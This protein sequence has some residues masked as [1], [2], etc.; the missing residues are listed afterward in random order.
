M[1]FLFLGLVPFSLHIHLSTRKKG[2]TGLELMFKSIKEAIRFRTFLADNGLHDSF[3]E[4][5]GHFIYSFQDLLTKK[6]H[7]LSAIV[8][9]IRSIKR[10]E[11]LNQVLIRKYRFENEDE[12]NEIMEIVTDMFN[13]ERE[14]LTSLVGVIAEKEIIGESVIDLLNF[15]GAV[16]FDS[17]LR[18]RLKNYFE[19][20]SGYLE[21]AIDE[22]KMEQDYQV[23]IQ[24]LR[25]YL[26][27]RN[28]KQNIVHLLLERPIHFFD[29]A[30]REMPDE[31][32]LD[33]LDPRL[34]SNHP[35]YVD[36]AVIAPLLSMAPKKI[37]LYT[38][39]EDQPLVRTLANIFEERLTIFPCH[40]LYSLSEAYSERS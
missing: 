19:R 26:H 28:T 33:I 13:G 32:I 34:L 10:N 5:R 22:Y 18:F 11:W 29:E 37:F 21:V 36:S 1:F 25:D 12:R 7:Y 40:Y 39:D 17:F 31:M 3:Q 38:K 27:K 20:V 23:F 15:D 4:K 30:L 8:Q 35:V 14:E 9:Y 24:M 6:D 2:G 16:A